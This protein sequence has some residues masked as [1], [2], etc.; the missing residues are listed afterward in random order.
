MQNDIRSTCRRMGGENNSPP[1]FDF[2]GPGRFWPN[3][4]VWARSGPDPKKQK[5]LLG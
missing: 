5:E 2:P 3:L 1:F 4:Y